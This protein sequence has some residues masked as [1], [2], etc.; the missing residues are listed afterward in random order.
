VE[1][2]FSQADDLAAK[3]PTKLKD[4]QDLFI[5]EAVKYHVLPIDD[6]S[7]ERMDPVVAGRPDLMQGRS[8]LTL[9]P[10][11]VGMAENV[12]ISVKN[13]SHAITAVVDV[14]NGGANGVIVAQGGRFGGW[15]LYLKEGKP[16]FV[17]NWLGLERY[18]IAAEGR[19]PDGKITL[20]YEFAYDGGKRGGGG[21]GTL[22]VDGRKVGEGRIEKTIPNIISVDET[23]NIGVDDETPVTEDYK[24]RDNKFAGKIHEVTVDV[25]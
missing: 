25:K 5:K 24:E 4:L 6:R 11:G 20:R 8:S 23:A 2:D 22:F 15:S 19:L 1:Q 21:K 14:P 12:F 13:R 3:H 16:T 17:Y 10:R 18:M 9:Y 7:V